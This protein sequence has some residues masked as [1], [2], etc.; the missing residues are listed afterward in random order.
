[1]EEKV[2]KELFLKNFPLIKKIE[3]MTGNFF[4]FYENKCITVVG[5]RVRIATDTPP[6]VKP[7]KGNAEPDVYI[8]RAR[9]FSAFGKLHIENWLKHYSP[10]RHGIA[11]CD[12]DWWRLSIYYSNR[13]RRLEI[14]GSND[15]PEEFERLIRLLNK[16]PKQKSIEEK[17]EGSEISI[18]PPKGKGEDKKE[19]KKLL[20]NPSTSPEEKARLIEKL[21]ENIDIM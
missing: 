14:S 2:N 12:G 19:V 5:D 3:L 16:R 18:L 7:D 9:F 15:Y 8:D 1:M 11:V 13:K 17:W 10:L 4:G 20:A 6:Y 21:Y